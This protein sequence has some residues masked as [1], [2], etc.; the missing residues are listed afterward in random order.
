MRRS[1]GHVLES[2]G[3]FRRAG[4]ARRVDRIVR[5]TR[6]AAW[7]LAAS[8]VAPA[9]LALAVPGVDVDAVRCAIKCGHAVRAG[10]VCCPT[11]AGTTW[12]TCRPD[13]SLLPGFA[14]AA[15][16]VLT[17]QFRL[18]APSGF[19]LLAPGISPA[20]RSSLDAPPDPVPL[21]LS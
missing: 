8:V 16:G 4:Q 15:V 11:D 10:A 17:P 18:A 14:S 12:K 21:A 20:P 6:V 1:E 7:I 9:L 3:F 19:F 13:D 2:E 5:V